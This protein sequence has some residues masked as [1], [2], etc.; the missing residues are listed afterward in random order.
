M[1]LTDQQIDTME[2]VEL[3]DALQS[4]KNTILQLIKYRNSIDAAD[5]EL[6][7][8]QNQAAKM[9][10]GFS[11]SAFITAGVIGFILG[12]IIG[13][14]AVGLFFGALVVIG[15]KIMDKRAD[16]K[17][18]AAAK[19]YIDQNYPPAAA[20][21]KELEQAYKEFRATD[22]VY[23]ASLLVPKDYFDPDALDSIL[24]LLKNRRAKNLSEA[25]NT[26]ETALHQQRVESLGHEQ[27]AVSVEGVIAQQRTANATEDT[28][29]SN[30][31]IAQN[32]RD[33]AH[34][35]RDIARNTRDI[36][37]TNREI[38][39]SARSIA[40]SQRA[41]ALSAAAIASSA[42]AMASN[43]TNIHV[44]VKNEIY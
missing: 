15:L 14:F 39:S 21:K 9:L 29:R 7:A 24:T 16:P 37:N 27:L 40:A 38:A 35:T 17:R 33:I 34:N 4:A 12:L 3:I 36:A 25:L 18:D 41:Q 20:R 30:R 28:A 5:Q 32:T 22:E 23:N 19:A 42:Q 43:K 8:I 44:E 11:R 31:V 1:K 26:Y 13:K 10:M 2:R 6:T